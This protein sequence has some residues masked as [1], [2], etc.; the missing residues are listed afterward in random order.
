MKTNPVV[1]NKILESNSIKFL[2]RTTDSELKFNKHPLNTF[3]AIVTKLSALATMVRLVSFIESQIQ[4]K[5]IFESKFKYCFLAWI[6]Y[7][8]TRNNK[9]NA[10][11]E[12]VL[13]LV[14]DDYQEEI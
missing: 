10:L 4:S 11:H 9:L 8:H 1:E 13:R 3:S 7:G 5:S 2:G 14:Y 6:F 12:R